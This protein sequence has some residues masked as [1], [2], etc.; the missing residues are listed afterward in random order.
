MGLTLAIPTC[1][2]CCGER[3]GCFKETG[4]ISPD[5]RGDLPLLATGVLGATGTG[6]LGGKHTEDCP[7]VSSIALDHTRTSGYITWILCDGVQG[8][9]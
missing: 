1:D 4:S 2:D 8:R 6:L 5:I 9:N 3:G 7:S